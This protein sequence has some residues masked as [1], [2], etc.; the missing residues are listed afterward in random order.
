MDYEHLRYEHDG[1]VVTLTYDRP[2]VHNALSRAMA[3]ELRFEGAVSTSWGASRGRPDFF[4][5]PRFT[6]WD[7]GRLRFVL[8]MARNLAA[9]AQQ[10]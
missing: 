6:P 3:R 10:A 2:E 5:L 7:Q 4:Q 1:H 9:N 8:R